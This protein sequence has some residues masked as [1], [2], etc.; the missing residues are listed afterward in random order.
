MGFFGREFNVSSHSSD[1]M[2]SSSIGT[3]ALA[4]W[5]SHG[6]TSVS[7]TSASH[8]G[9]GALV[10][11]ASMCFRFSRRMSVFSSKTLP[12][13][14]LRIVMLLLLALA[15]LDRDLYAW[16]DSFL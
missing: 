3:S 5:A 2:W 7:S 6:G 16:L 1:V 10:L 4:A 9:G 8:C 11:M 15:F 12:S 14:V 13:F